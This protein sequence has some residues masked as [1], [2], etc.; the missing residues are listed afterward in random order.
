MRVSCCSAADRA[1]PRG[2]ARPPSDR[3]HIGIFRAWR[4]GRMWDRGGWVEVRNCVGKFSIAD[5]TGVRGCA[6]LPSAL[7]HMAIF[8]A[9]EGGNRVE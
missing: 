5:R 8:R 4:S 1:G 9:W 3:R 7:R 6:R 2:W